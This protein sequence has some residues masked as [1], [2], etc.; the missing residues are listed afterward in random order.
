MI[1]VQ[2]TDAE[3]S[4]NDSS[5]KNT[6][7]VDNTVID[8]RR[9]ITYPILS[10]YQIPVQQVQTENVIKSHIFLKITEDLNASDWIIVLETCM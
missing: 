10:L 2:V 3:L 7:F 1:S 6:K 5:S 8:G 9:N 4:W